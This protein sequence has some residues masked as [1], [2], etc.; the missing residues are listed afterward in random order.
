MNRGYL[1]FAHNNEIDYTEIALLNALMIRRHSGVRNVTLVTDQLS[2]DAAREKHGRLF[3]LA[4]QHIVIRPVPDTRQT[5]PFSD[6]TTVKKLKWHNGSRA[7][8]YE[9]SPYRE[10]ILLDADYLI[11]DGVLD[12][13]WGSYD[14]FLMN[15]HV[16]TLTGAP[17]APQEVRLEPYGVP[18]Y[19]ATCVFFRKGETAQ[20]MFEMVEHVRDH[21]DYYQH[22]YRFPGGLF[23]ND[24]AF[25]IAAH[26]I[27]GWTEGGI[28]S[29]PCPTLLTSFDT[30]QLIDVKDGLV[31]LSEGDLVKVSG[32]SVHV[33]NK[34]SIS[35]HIDKLLGVYREDV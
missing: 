9:I 29:L 10:T 5:R 35:R 3:N 31:F 30:D 18:L 27:G 6:G 34:F 13:A 28:N 19:W 16:T 25:S 12:H 21:Y 4:F 1:I 32:T 8:A 23:R 24:Y 15:R 11:Q 33:M 26:L 22:L 14:D 2:L 7:T 17:P 20:R